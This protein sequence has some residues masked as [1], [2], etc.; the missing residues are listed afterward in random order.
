MKL[1]NVHVFL[2]RLGGGNIARSNCGLFKQI[3]QRAMESN[4]A[5]SSGAE[6]PTGDTTAEGAAA[7]AAEF[8]S[9]PEFEM[10]DGCKVAS[11]LTLSAERDIL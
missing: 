11:A 8:P 4:W 9:P 1:F 7:A 10:M 5:K 2:L 3:M 6:S